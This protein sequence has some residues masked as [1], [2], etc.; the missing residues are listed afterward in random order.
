MRKDHGICQPVG[1]LQPRSQRIGKRMAGG[2]VHRAKADA[3]IIGR[4]KQ[5]CAGLGIAAVPHGAGE[6]AGNKAK[7][8]AGIIVDQGMSLAVG[9]GLDAMSHCVDPCGGRDGGRHGHCQ[10]RIKGHHIRHQEAAFDGNLVERCGIRHQRADAR[11][12]PRSCR[13]R[14]QRQRVLPRGD[15][16]RADDVRQ[17]LVAAQHG[18]Q[19]CQIHDRTPAETDHQIGGSGPGSGKGRLQIVGIRFRVDP[20]EDRDLARQA[21]PSDQGSQNRLGQH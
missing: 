12:G 10:V 8:Q 15:P 3:A 9:K 18:H 4:Q 5:G 19:L 13:C 14:H 2:G 21:K 20:V 1:Q 11:L 16:M 6:V 7:A 17:R